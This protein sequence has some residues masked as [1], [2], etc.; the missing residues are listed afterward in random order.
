MLDEHRPDAETEGTTMISL[1]EQVSGVSVV[2][3]WD[4]L[5]RSQQPLSE[6]VL[7]SAT[8]GQFFA[9]EDR[10][11]MSEGWRPVFVVRDSA[12]E[13]FV[14]FDRRGYLIVEPSEGLKDGRQSVTDLVEEYSDSGFYYRPPKL[15]PS[16]SKRWGQKAT[17]TS[18]PHPLILHPGSPSSLEESGMRTE[19]LVVN[20][21]IAADTSAGAASCIEECVSS[22]AGEDASSQAD[23]QIASLTTAAN[24]QPS[25]SWP[26]EEPSGQPDGA[27]CKDASC[28]ADA[29]VVSLSTT[30]YVQPSTPTPDE[31][32]SAQH[33]GV[34]VK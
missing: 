27:G 30:A 2:P 34:S 31:E 14:V 21:Q 18:E 3:S 15:R 23:E 8:P 13:S 25:T 1:S 24:A 7:Q 32:L 33:E 28:E 10:N 29:E 17:R 16:P 26:E 11:I 20:N 22:Q 12:S 6:Q 9:L 4:V 19:E 5:A